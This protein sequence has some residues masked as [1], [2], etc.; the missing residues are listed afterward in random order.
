M[1]GETPI[2]PPGE[3]YTYTSAC[4]LPTPTGSMEGEFGFVIKSD[5]EDSTAEERSI[6]VCVDRFHLLMEAGVE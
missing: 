6:D 3:S 2:I 1:V 5:A 4:P